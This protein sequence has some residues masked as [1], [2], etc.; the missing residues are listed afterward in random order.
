M[1]YNLAMPFLGM[2]T[3]K[4]KQGHR[5]LCAHVRGSIIHNGQKVGTTEVSIYVWM[6]KQN[7]VSL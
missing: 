6:G 7:V 1:K 4:L 2:Y 5:Y 3:K